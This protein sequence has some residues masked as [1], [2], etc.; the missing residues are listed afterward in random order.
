[1]GMLLVVRCFQLLRNPVVIVSLLLAGAWFFLSPSTT[2]VSSPDGGFTYPGYDVRGVEDFTIEA[3]VLSRQNYHMG[4]EADLSPTDLAIGWGPMADESI[5]ADFQISQRNRWYFWK[6]RQ[7][8][9]SRNEVITHS[10]NVHIIPA[11][12][13][14]SDALSQVRTNDQ[15]RLVG[16]LVDVNGDDGWRWRTS[17]SRS[18]TGNG[19]CEVLWLERLEFI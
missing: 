16:Q 7:M 14:V 3:R 1:M 8:P 17:R 10:A 13:D 5:L 2:A 9:I 19:S 6:A 4:R 12:A 18:D 15:V 11:N